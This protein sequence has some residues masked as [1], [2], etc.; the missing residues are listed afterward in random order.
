MNRLQWW[1]YK[2]V[3][4]PAYRRR[5]KSFWSKT[6]TERETMLAR[7]ATTIRNLVKR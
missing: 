6:P 4:E 5:L 3:T 2:K 7:F 1:W